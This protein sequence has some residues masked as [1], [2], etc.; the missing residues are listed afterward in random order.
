M[1]PCLVPCWCPVGALLVPCLFLEEYA[2][3][4]REGGPSYTLRG[5]YHSWVVGGVAAAAAAAAA[6]RRTRRSFGGCGGGSAAHVA[7][8]RCEALRAP[9]L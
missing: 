4:I 5:M 8:V 7:L 1:V 6:A 2:H 9:G 3:F